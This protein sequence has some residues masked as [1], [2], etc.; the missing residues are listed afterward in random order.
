M[1]QEEDL[2]DRTSRYLEAREAGEAV[3]VEEV[4]ADRPDL[5]AEL[6]HRL[7]FLDRLEQLIAADEPSLSTAHGESGQPT[8]PPPLPLAL[9]DLPG[10][11]VVGVLGEGGMGVVYKARHRELD[12]LVAL[13]MI[14]ASRLS[15][16]MLARFQAE[17]RA[18]A[19]L[20]HPHI[21][22]IYEIGEYRPAGGGPALPY[23][24]LEYIPGRSLGACLAGGPIDPLE[25][26]RL[27]LLLARAVQ[28]AHEAG[29]IHRD[30]KPDN[31]L[32]TADGTPKIADVGMANKL[33][34]PGPPRNG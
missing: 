27:L 16:D 7:R 19:R 12:R 14:H 22:K 15:P 5:A 10:Y 24:A 30:L 11:D 2:Q 3:S 31:V 32:L 20:D 6:A 34:E 25:A 33:G 23:L 29:V 26:A 17:A 13:K 8:P 28:H 4:C 21:V 1:S 18:V 9:P